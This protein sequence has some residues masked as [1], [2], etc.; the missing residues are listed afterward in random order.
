LY[1]HRNNRVTLSFTKENAMF[2]PTKKQIAS[3][4]SGTALIGIVAIMAYAAVFF[5]PSTQPIGYI[6]QPTL[7]NF[8]ATTGTSLV[9]RG[10]YNSSDWSGRFD[11][12]PV[13]ANGYVNLASPCF[14]SGASSPL[15][16]Q[17]AAS[18][19]FIGTRSDAAT[20]PGVEFSTTGLTVT[21]QT[22]AG[23]AGNINYI[24]GA[25]LSPTGLRARTT[26]L[27][28]IIHSRPYYY[29]DGVN[30]TVFVGANDGMLHAFDASSGTTAGQERWAYIPSMLISKP[31]FS[32]FSTVGYTNAHDYFVD[33]SMAI[34]KVGVGTSAKTVLV[35][36]LGAGGKGLYA[37]DIST[38]TAANGAAAGAKG[39]WEITN[40]AWISPTSKANSTSYANL[41][42][43]YSNPLLVPTQDGSSSVIVGNG[44][45]NVGNGHAVLYVI[46]AATGSKIAEIDTGSGSTTSPDG[47]SSPVAI[48]SNGDGKA[49]RVYAGDIDGNMWVFDLSGT[50]PL[51][52]SVTKLYATGKAITQAP[53]VATHPY[54]GYMVDF[55]T[56]RILSGPNAAV[57]ASSVTAATDDTKDVVTQYA[58][59][60]LWDNLSGTTITTTQLVIQSAVA[61]TYPSATAS[62]ASAVAER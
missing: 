20:A 39:L 43:T 6:G 57:V 51:S 34:G 56:G 31:S 7:S 35:G 5:A 49:D 48:D 4:I 28:D 27:G 58:V 46:N 47:L 40:T 19:R 52:W 2:K 53:T 44:Y 32:T 10:E 55:A 1:R 37:L 41:G 17:A 24:R 8:N 62:A 29:T 25:T 45:N 33:G 12:Y 61:N 13:G 21:Q 59:Y 15:D 14:L 42:D 9:Y 18:T 3:A 22:A 60:G 38:L 36:A 11:C 26:V 50:A 23:G 54:G 30:P 16:T